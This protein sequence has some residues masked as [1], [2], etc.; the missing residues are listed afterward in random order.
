MRAFTLQA[1]DHAFAA[2]LIKAAA[3]AGL[4]LQGDPDA[5]AVRLE[6]RGERLIAMAGA[7]AADN[8]DNNA[9][10]TLPLPARLGAIVDWLQRLA[11]RVPALT[12]PDGATRLEPQ[13][14]R[15]VMD[16]GKAVPL[17][18]KEIDMLAYL[19]AQAR[20][21]ARAELLQAVWGYNPE[22]DTHTLETH[23]YR[24]RQKLEGAGLPDVLQ[25]GEEGYSL[26]R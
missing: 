22:A 10:E 2:A 6:Q 11:R 7:A 26:G 17:T 21:V 5:G 24:L 23:V 9:A 15:I 4:A 3:A 12:F 18:E 1:E 25:T 13:A 14:R 16:G 8:T 20:P 19:A